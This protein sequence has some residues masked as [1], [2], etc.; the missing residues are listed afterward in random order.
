MARA[1]ESAGFKLLVVLVAAGVVGGLVVARQR[2]GGPP[3][4]ASSV[5]A[6]GGPPPAS[7]SPLTGGD[8]GLAAAAPDAAPADV[9]ALNAAITAGDLPRI[10]ELAKSTSLQ[11]TLATAAATGN[12]GVVTWLLDHGVDPHEGE[13][14][15]S[16]PIL[17]AD[18]YPSVVELLLARGARETTLSGALDGA[19]PGALKRLL[20][21]GAVVDVAVANEAAASRIANVDDLLLGGKLTPE[22]AYFMVQKERDPKR[23]AAIAAKGVAW[24]AE[25]PLVSPTPPLVAAAR[26]LDVPR[27]KALLTAGAPVDRAGEGGETPLFSA[28]DAAA[29][30]QE[31]AA[32]I[33][34]ALLGKSA[35]PNKRAADGRRPLHL[36][37][38]KGEEAIVKS[39]LAKGAHVDDEVGG[40]TPLEAAESNGHQGVAR[41]LTAAGAKRKKR[42]PD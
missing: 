14:S 29:P 18:A 37:A 38:E 19:A 30:D 36:A 20:A 28:I 12:V 9:S 1:K 5:V 21:K 40:T 42:T 11:G 16:P 10:E 6:A 31:D 4:A 39:L 7:A 3:P 25:H 32:K 34:D 13:T 35:N 33:V 17:A 8:A 22:A 27:A 15:T 24:N 23:I 2:L 41:L 26:A